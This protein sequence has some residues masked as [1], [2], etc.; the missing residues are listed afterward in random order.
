M[1]LAGNRFGRMAIAVARREI[2][3]PINAARIIKQHLLDDT[4]GFDKALPIHRP[5]DT[6]ATNAV[7]DRNLVGC[8]QLVLGLHHPG[9]A[10]A[11]FS[12]MLFD[13]GQRQSQRRAS[14]LQ[15]TRQFGD[16]GADHRRL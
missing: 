13:P 6:Q 15:P 3:R 8:L 5:D 10:L 11:G 2:H 12:Q 4:M 7:A 9:D 14:P 1:A 16:K